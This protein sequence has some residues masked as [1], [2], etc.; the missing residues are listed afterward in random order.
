MKKQNR[1]SIDLLLAAV[2]LT[3]ASTAQAQQIARISTVALLNAIPLPQTSKA[4][5]GTCT[6][7]TDASNGLVSIVDNG[8][9]FND[10]SDQLNQYLNSGMGMPATGSTPAKPPTPEQIEQMK[11][12]AMQQMAQAQAAAQAG[13]QNPSAQPRSPG[14][15]APVDD[16]ALMRQ[17]GQ[18]QGLAVQASQIARE[19]SAKVGA[20]D[21][22]G[23]DHVSQGPNCPEVQQ[24]GYAG[25]TC[26]CMTAKEIKYRKART[27]QQD[28]YLAKVVDLIQEYL[29]KIKAPPTAVDDLMVK[30]KYGDGLVNPM[31]KQQVGMM[32][33]Q[34]LGAVVTLL[35]LSG[36]LWTDSGSVYCYNVNAES[37]ATLRCK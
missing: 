9:T 11:Q 5:F 10:M 33:R 2:I 29:P 34:A 16:P 8:K 4:C 6:K 3:M 30:A 7:K 37:G 24:G 26:A 35:A 15:A 19:L 12:H 20:I 14:A 25:P 28:L 36:S 23:F 17:F 1:L 21:R 18:A 27:E 31:F 13:A 22:S 32:Q